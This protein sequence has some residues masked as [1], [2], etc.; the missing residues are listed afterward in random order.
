M[1]A[2]PVVAPPAVSIPVA[3]AMK[4]EVVV[5]DME[6]IKQLAVEKLNNILQLKDKLTLSSLYRPEYIGKL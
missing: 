1:V 5:D 3:P 4:K 6:L 2:S